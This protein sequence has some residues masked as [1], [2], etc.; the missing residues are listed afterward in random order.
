[1]LLFLRKVVHVNW[2]ERRKAQLNRYTSFLTT[3]STKIG[4][5]CGRVYTG[6][7]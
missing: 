7:L 1:M 4:F 2:L 5:F 3:R 6:R